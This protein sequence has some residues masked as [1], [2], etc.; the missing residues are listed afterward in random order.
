MF[1]FANMAEICA[2]VRLVPH[3]C[4]HITVDQSHSSGD[5]VAKI[6][7]ISREW[8]HKDYHKDVR[9]Y[10]NRNLPQI[11]IG[12][13]GKEDDAFMRWPPRSPELVPCDFF[14]GGL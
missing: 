4:Q 3:M 8:R 11:W 9:V 1:T 2:I 12:R 10:L 5:T 14:S 7:E 13:T 6:L